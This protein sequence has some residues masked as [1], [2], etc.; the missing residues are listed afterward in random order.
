M[1]TTMTA[2]SNA[3]TF[4]QSSADEANA[5]RNVNILVVDSGQS[6]NAPVGD[7]LEVRKSER[8]IAYNVSRAAFDH[9]QNDWFRPAGKTAGT[10]TLVP[11]LTQ[12]R[13]EIVVFCMPNLAERDCSEGSKDPIVSAIRACAKMSNPPRI[14]V[15]EA[16]G[17]GLPQYEE[18]T[19]EAIAALSKQTGLSI[20]HAFSFELAE[21]F[22]VI[23]AAAASLPAGRPAGS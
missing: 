20:K 16:P 21:A 13:P 8:N 5:A 7:Y 12:D 1:G 23:E 9:V 11:M 19:E 18:K 4:A 15:H 14:V 10:P 3:R 17:C 6:G 22:A 2:G